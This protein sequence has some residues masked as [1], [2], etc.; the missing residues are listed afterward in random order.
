[1]MMKVVLL[2]IECIVSEV[3]YDRGC[4]DGSVGMNE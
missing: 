4:V 1:M 2:A 3:F